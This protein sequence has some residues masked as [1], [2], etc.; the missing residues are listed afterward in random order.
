MPLFYPLLLT[1]HIQW[2]MGD[3]TRQ[4]GK[5]DGRFLEASLPPCSRCTALDYFLWSLLHPHYWAQEELLSSLHQSE[6]IT[7]LPHM[8]VSL[9]PSHTSFHSS[10]LDKG[11]TE[12]TKRQEVR[13]AYETHTRGRPKMSIHDVVRWMTARGRQNGSDWWWF[14]STLL[15]CYVLA[16]H[17]IPLICSILGCMSIS[18][19][20][21][22]ITMSLAEHCYSALPFNW[23][24]LS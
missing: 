23:V 20:P 24:F 13:R 1:A 14:S 22:C 3:K 18:G 16:S 9:L 10:L 12:C 15:H 4:E 6:K 19:C 21:N 7:L 11:A 8:I 2:V 17:T 5:R